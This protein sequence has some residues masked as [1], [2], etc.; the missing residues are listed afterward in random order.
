[1]K[2]IF[3]HTILVLSLILVLSACNKDK[4]NTDK[5]ENLEKKITELTKEN[6]NLK[7]KITALETE[8]KEKTTNQTQYKGLSKQQMML[9]NS[10]MKGLNSKPDFMVVEY[11]SK[12]NTFRH[13][14]WN[15][16]GKKPT[17]NKNFIE[18]AI[19]QDKQLRMVTDNITQEFC[20]EEEANSPFLAIKNGEILIDKLNL[21][22]LLN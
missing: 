8:K 3:K 7:S 19:K 16:N 4:E 11:D 2:K 9:L 17:F 6:D 10:F 5:V 15:I 12:T 22:S 1:M 13:N 18:T 14:V 21:K 20:F